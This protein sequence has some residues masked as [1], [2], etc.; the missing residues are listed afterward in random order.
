MLRCFWCSAS[1]VVAATTVGC[2]LRHLRLCRRAQ[3]VVVA[4]DTD[5]DESVEALPKSTTSAT[6]QSVLL[7]RSADLAHLDL[8]VLED[9]LPEEALYS[10]S[11]DGYQMYFTSGTTSLPKAVVLTHQIVCSHAMG[12]IQ[13]M[14]FNACDVWFHVYVLSFVLH[15]PRTTSTC[16][17]FYRD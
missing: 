1:D 11:H 9:I 7:P 2:R 6:F 14:R 16:S 3:A 15:C 12:A 5:A 10:Q 13:E 8:Q 4:Q 17:F